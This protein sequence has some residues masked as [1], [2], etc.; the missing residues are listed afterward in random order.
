MGRDAQAEYA[1]FAVIVVV[2]VAA[3]AV[4]LVVGATHP[5][6]SGEAS[7]CHSVVRD[8]PFSGC[9]T[10]SELTLMTMVLVFPKWLPRKH[11]PRFL[12][13]STVPPGSLANWGTLQLSFT[14]SA[15][16]IRGNVR[17]NQQAEFPR[18]VCRQKGRA[19][20]NRGEVRI[21]NMSCMKGC[22]CHPSVD[23]TIQR[24]EMR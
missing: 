6:E 20:K 12:S 22:I 8:W 9:S 16:Y 5:L 11:F 24:F 7:D 21:F 19:A 17:I 10:R 2:V 18:I 3:A 14:E 1:S 4:S 23:P 13:T 15:L